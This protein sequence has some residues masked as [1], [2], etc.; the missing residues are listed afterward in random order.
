MQGWIGIETEILGRW[1]NARSFAGRRALPDR[2]R[3]M[4]PGRQRLIGLAACR[5]QGYPAILARH[6]LSHAPCILVGSDLFGGRQP[7][8]RLAARGP[9]L[10]VFEQILALDALI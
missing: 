7:Q 5:P 8:L 1:R 9:E 10:D 3:V 6:L 2:A 4:R